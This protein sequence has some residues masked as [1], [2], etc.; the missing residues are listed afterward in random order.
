M[1]KC[2]GIFMK[3]L[4]HWV[5]K[6]KLKA[7]IHPVVPVL[8]ETRH[9]VGPYNT[10]LQKSVNAADYATW[11]DVYDKFLDENGA[12]RDIVK[13]DGTHCHPA[14]LNFVEEWFSKL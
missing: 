11:C 2:I 3:V 7:Y 6:K 9:I 8:N 1:H 14:Y 5:G 10:I 12:L 4:K 13:L